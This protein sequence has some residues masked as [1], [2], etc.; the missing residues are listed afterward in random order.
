MHIEDYN[1][2]NDNNELVK[3]DIYDMM[4]KGL[5]VNEKRSEQ[6]MVEIGKELISKIKLLDEECHILNPNRVKWN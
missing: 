3:I 1:K 4:K 5:K 2:M 6:F